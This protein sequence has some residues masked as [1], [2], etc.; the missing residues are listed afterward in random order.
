MALIFVLGIL[1]GYAPF[2][3]FLITVSLAVA[4]IPEGLPTVVTI[5]LAIGVQRMAAHHAVIRKLPAVE[6]L[7]AA[8]VICTDKTG[9]L[10]KNEMTVRR[11]FV[12]GS[13]FMVTGEGYT[14]T[15]TLLKDGN[16]VTEASD[17]KALDTL[18]TTGILANTSRL[19]RD[20]VTG[21]VE[22]AGD[23]TE[24][25]LLVLAEKGGLDRKEVKMKFP[26]GDELPFDSIRKMM[27]VICHVEDHERAFVK[28]APEILLARCDRILMGGT[29]R[30]LTGRDQEQVN[31]AVRQ[32]GSGALRVLAFAYRDIVTGDREKTEEHLV[33]VG[34]ARD[35][36]PAPPGSKGGCFCL[37]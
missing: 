4:A 6:V 15:G 27:T 20:P 16:E 18:L 14:G 23:P 1:R 9:T 21:T 25:A 22:I 5:T 24:T 12:N 17:Q 28:G 32:M 31:D 30:T 34:L 36:R 29:E 2:E 3:L 19:T 37:S 33:F 13:F 11:L 26:C 10:T 7:G 8:T 35:D